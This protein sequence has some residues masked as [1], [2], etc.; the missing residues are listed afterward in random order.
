[1]QRDRHLRSLLISLALCL[2]P[3]G[4]ALADDM[5]AVGGLFF[6]IPFAADGTGPE[7]PRLGFGVGPRA[8]PRAALSFEMNSDGLARLGLAGYR[9]SWQMAPPEAWG[10]GLRLFEDATETAEPDE[11]LPKN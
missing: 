7:P 2:A 9:W 3:A 5:D 1:M 10:S 8:L 6:R 11:D 4:G